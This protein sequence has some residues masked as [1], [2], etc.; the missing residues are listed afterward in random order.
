MLLGGICCGQHVD[1]TV[2]LQAG[3]VAGI[4]VGADDVDVALVTV[5]LGSQRDIAAGLDGRANRGGAGLVLFTFAAAFADRDADID[6]GTGAAGCSSGKRQDLTPA[7]FIFGL[8]T[9]SLCPA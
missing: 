5:A 6:C 9:P 1:R 3:V 8:F 2:G 4:D 7:T